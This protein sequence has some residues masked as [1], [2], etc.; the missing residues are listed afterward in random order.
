MVTP[1]Q[2]QLNVTYIV[3]EDLQLLHF[4]WDDA[5]NPQVI[6]GPLDDTG[7]CK[8]LWEIVLGNRVPKRVFI[9]INLI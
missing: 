5:D 8:E 6:P 7:I 9:E 3:K 1:I 4:T 2:P